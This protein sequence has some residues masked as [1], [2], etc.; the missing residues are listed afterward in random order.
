MGILLLAAPS[1]S[2]KGV[3]G[4]GL[5]RDG[6]SRWP[7]PRERAGRREGAGSPD[8]EGAAGIQETPARAFL[9]REPASGHSDP[10]LGED[11]L[12][13]QTEGEA[14]P[15]C[16]GPEFVPPRGLTPHLRSAGHCRH[17]HSFLSANVPSCFFA[18]VSSLGPSAPCH[19]DAHTRHARIRC[20]ALCLF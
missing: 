17:S 9:P 6:V 4:A 15:F 11:E 8:T 19:A 1:L 2:M 12:A 18:T 13:E 14:G 3:Q 7:V 16:Q 20:T 5:A 10:L